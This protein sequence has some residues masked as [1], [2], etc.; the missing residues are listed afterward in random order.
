MYVFPGTQTHVVYPTDAHTVQSS[1]HPQ[2]WTTRLSSLQN[3][4][5]VEKV[6]KE[7]PEGNEKRKRHRKKNIRKMKTSNHQRLVLHI[8]LPKKTLMWIC[9]NYPADIVIALSPD[10]SNEVF[11]L[12][13]NKVTGGRG[14]VERERA[15]ER[16][17]FETIVHYPFPPSLFWPLA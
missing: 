3:R 17:H 14:D 13:E 4:Q 8:Q 5:Q 7:R 6:M 15:R 2:G 12:D 9:A 1:Q 16:G 11:C 10:E